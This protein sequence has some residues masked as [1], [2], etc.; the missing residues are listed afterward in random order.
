MFLVKASEGA[1]QRCEADYGCDRLW[2]S[3]AIRPTPI[4]HAVRFQNGSLPADMSMNDGI[5]SPGNAQAI[6]DQAR[7]PAETLP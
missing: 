1:V 4:Q 3:A 2:S 5:R 7:V 6:S